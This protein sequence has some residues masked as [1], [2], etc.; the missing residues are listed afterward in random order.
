MTVPLWLK[1]WLSGAKG[2]PWSCM[3]C[4]SAGLS[5]FLSWAVGSG[6]RKLHPCKRGDA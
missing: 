1:L 2:A 6:S 5:A 4:G 3:F